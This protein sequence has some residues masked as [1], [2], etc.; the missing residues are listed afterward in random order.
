MLMLLCVCVSLS[1]SN[2]HRDKKRRLISYIFYSPPPSQSHH[3]H[4]QDRR[5]SRE[6]E[7]N[8]LSIKYQN[9]MC[10]TSKIKKIKK[11]QIFT[12]SKD[13]KAS[14]YKSKE[15]VSNF[16]AI[17]RSLKQIFPSEKITPRVRFFFFFLSNFYELERSRETTTSSIRNALSSL[18]S[19]CPL[20]FVNTLA[21]TYALSLFSYF[22]DFYEKRTN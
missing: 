15:M 10:H 2:H 18:S 20:I 3:P 1:P 6:K 11:I 8:L 5:S 17:A 7:K 13:T 16:K 19:L 22:F 21:N 12:M 14:L 9:H 4:H